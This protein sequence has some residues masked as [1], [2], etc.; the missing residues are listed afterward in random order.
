MSDRRALW[1]AG[2]LAAA[3]LDGFQASLV[4]D[5]EGQVVGVQLELPVG[6]DPA[7]QHSVK[8]KH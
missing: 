8:L 6:I 2:V 1:L 7:D 3:A 5:D 4:T